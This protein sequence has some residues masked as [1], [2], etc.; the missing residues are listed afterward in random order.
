MDRRMD[1][2]DTK[3]ISE[4]ESEVTFRITEQTALTCGQC[5][6]IEKLYTHWNEKTIKIWLLKK[7]LKSLSFVIYE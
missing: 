6:G 7:I 2:I 4:T 3:V 5:F 1:L